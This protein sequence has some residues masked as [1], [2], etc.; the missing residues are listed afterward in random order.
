M[1]LFRELWQAQQIGLFP[2]NKFLRTALLHGVAC[3]TCMY[4]LQHFIAPTSPEP[5]VEEEP[6]DPKQVAGW[7]A[8][9]RK[10][11]QDER[12]EKIKR[13]RTRFRGRG[14]LQRAIVEAQSHIFDDLEEGWSW[15]MCART[16]IGQSDYGDPTLRPSAVLTYSV[17]ASIARIRGEIELATGELERASL[18]LENHFQDLQSP[19]RTVNRIGTRLLST[20]FLV[21][22]RLSLELGDSLAAERQLLAA[23]AFC[24]AADNEE[25]IQEQIDEYLAQARELARR[26][27]SYGLDELCLELLVSE[28]KADA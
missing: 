10:L 25:R 20:H 7:M 2:H 14:F 23:K 17:V 6:Y 24:Y 19:S 8:E 12:L 16:S 15:A 3:Q 9:L 13:A 4:E 11:D 26:R 5:E 22:G 28:E 27:A 1:H 18:A 21:K